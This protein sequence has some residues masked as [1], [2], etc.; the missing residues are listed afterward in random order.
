MNPYIMLELVNQKRRDQ[1]I[2]PVELDQRLMNVIQFQV[3]YCADNNTLS[4]S[5]PAGDLGTR[6]RNFNYRYHSCAEN[7]A[8]NSGE[9]ARVME[10]WMESPGHR[11]NILNRSHKH[12]GVGFKNSYWGQAF[13]S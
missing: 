6:F 7:L 5:N 8:Y 2:P 10:S 9:E 13:G 3:D 11:A 12:M 4:H 1:N